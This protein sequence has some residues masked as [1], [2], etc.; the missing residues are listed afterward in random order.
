MTEPST[1]IEARI[2]AFILENLDGSTDLE[3][4]DRLMDKGYIPSMQLINLVGFLEDT[5]GVEIVPFDVTP[6]N[7]ESVAAIA[8][9]VRSLRD[10]K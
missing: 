3:Y 6:E 8:D 4:D 1:D 7:F 2:R 5:F 10:G 9:L